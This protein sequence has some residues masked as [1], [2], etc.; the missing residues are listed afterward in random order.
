MGDSIRSK[1]FGGREEGVWGR[2][3]VW[4]KVPSPT[5]SLRDHLPKNRAELGEKGA[6]GLY[7]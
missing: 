6:L 7:H 3:P 5:F 1:V 2:G 4:G